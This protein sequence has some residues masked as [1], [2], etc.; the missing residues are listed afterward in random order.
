MFGS[1]FRNHYLKSYVMFSSVEPGMGT[2]S[3]ITVMET[4]DI[5]APAQCNEDTAVC[6]ASVKDLKENWQK[7]SNEQQEYQKHNPFSHDSQTPCGGPPEGTGR[8]WEA[9]AG[10]L[11]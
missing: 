9:P 7:W 5:P 2:N 11:D 1:K 10:L 8:L 3:Q 4:E 6:V